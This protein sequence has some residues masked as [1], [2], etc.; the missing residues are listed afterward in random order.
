[1]KTV[2]TKDRC[3]SGGGVALALVCVPIALASLGCG[4]PS[5][6]DAEDTP[7]APAAAGK[8]DVEVRSQAL[9]DANK[10]VTVPWQSGGA[11]RRVLQASSTTYATPSTHL[12]ALVYVSGNFDRTNNNWVNVDSDDTSWFIEGD[13]HG[14]QGS[15]A[16]RCVP[17]TF[18]SAFR[19]GQVSFSKTTASVSWQWL[20]WGNRI[21]TLTGLS[22]TFDGGGEY[23]GT[24]RAY[25][26]NPSNPVH[27]AHYLEDHRETFGAPRG[28]GKGRSTFIGAN[29]FYAGQAPVRYMGTGWGTYPSPIFA[30]SPTV[31]GSI[32][33]QF[34]Y[35][36][37]ISGK[38][39]GNGEWVSVHASNGN[40]VLDGNAIDPQVTAAQ[41][42]CVLY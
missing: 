12:C 38:F 5:D 41:A 25:D 34:C 3:F 14:E 23:V 8:D 7:V 18:F 10:T 19:Q 1:M 39:R 24:G 26:S 32:S 37:Y 11:R 21:N 42:E 35:L 40:W 2:S 16:A 17:L 9:F 6:T 27:W 13:F 29:V 33:T 22:G 15:A 28:F 4:T 30:P 31:L 20:G 36:S